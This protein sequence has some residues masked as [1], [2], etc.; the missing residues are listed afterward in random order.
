MTNT[1]TENIRKWSARQRI[2]RRIIRQAVKDALVRGY[3]ISVDNGECIEVSRSRSLKAVMDAI[4]ATD[5]DFLLIH[6]FDEELGRYGPSIGWVRLIYG[7]D[8]WD[9]VN[10]YTTNLEPMMEAANALA[11]KLS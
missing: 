4:M 5:E 6:S 7:N 9:V 8:G 11:E 2:E 3:A 1:T 10:D